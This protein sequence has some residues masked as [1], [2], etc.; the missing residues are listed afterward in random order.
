MTDGGLDKAPIA[1][2][3]RPMFPVA[4]SHFPPNSLTFCILQ[5]SPPPQ[6]SPRLV[7]CHHLST[8]TLPV[9]LSP[10]PNSR[11]ISFS[12][13]RRV[14]GLV[15]WGGLWEHEGREIIIVYTEKAYVA[16]VGISIYVC[17]YGNTNTS[18]VRL[19]IYIYSLWLGLC[20]NTLTPAMRTPRPC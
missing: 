10:A 1:S 3:H 6:S 13:C 12:Q 16:G 14:A 2:A 8:A 7:S 18:H 15:G 17:I 11:R 5:F 9:T 19:R 4:A 20:P